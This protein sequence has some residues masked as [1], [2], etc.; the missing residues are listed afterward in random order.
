MWLRE[1]YPG[2][3]ILC[4][5]YIKEYGLINNIAKTSTTM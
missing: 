1:T 2:R 3:L 4:Q 5:K